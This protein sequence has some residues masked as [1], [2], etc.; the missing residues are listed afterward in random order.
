MKRNYYHFEGRGESQISGKGKLRLEWGGEGRSERARGEESMT[1]SPMGLC[2]PLRE[3]TVQTGW[4]EWTGRHT[5]P[6]SH[7]AVVGTTTDTRTHA[8]AHNVSAYIH[9]YIDCVGRINHNDKSTPLQYCLRLAAV[10][11]ATLHKYTWST[12]R[13]LCEI[14]LH[15]LALAKSCRLYH[16]TE[17]TKPDG[18]L[19]IW[20]RLCSLQEPWLYASFV[21]GNLLN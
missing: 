18:F 12:I 6:Q 7:L 3:G 21:C 13:R 9:A 14:I 1:T 2:N 16:W 5:D 20:W 19:N 11:Y 8:H 15:A 17:R 10:R 4:E